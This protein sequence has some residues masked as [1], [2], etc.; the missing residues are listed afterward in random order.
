MA[1]EAGVHLCLYRRRGVRHLETQPWRDREEEETSQE[2]RE[3]RQGEDK[4]SKINCVQKKC[5]LV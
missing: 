1:V 5:V 4:E 3:T 2:I